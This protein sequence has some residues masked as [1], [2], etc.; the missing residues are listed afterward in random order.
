MLAFVFLFLQPEP[1]PPLWHLEWFPPAE[2]VEETCDFLD[3]HLR[4]LGN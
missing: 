2:V 1:L 4:W 3:A